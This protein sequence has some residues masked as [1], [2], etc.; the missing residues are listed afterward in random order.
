MGKISDPQRKAARIAGFTYLFTD[1]TAI[2]AELYVRGQLIVSGN[3]AQTAANIVAHERLFRLGIACELITFFGIILLAVAFYVALKP[4]S[5]GLALLGA[6]WRLAENT[7]LAVMTFS[8]FQVLEFL[9]NPVYSRSFDADR[10]Q[11]LMRLSI[12]AHGDQYQVGLLFAGLGTAVFAYLLFKSRYI[13]RVLAAL[14]VFASLL[15]AVSVLAFIIFPNLTD[16]VG[17]WCYIPLLIFEVGTGFWL[18][19]KGLPAD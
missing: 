11:S 17:F 8:S 10:L 6:F 2:F 9:T 12:N 13:P 1:V 4:I 16:L 18:L 5:P 14:G 3:P 15:T 19:I 7:I